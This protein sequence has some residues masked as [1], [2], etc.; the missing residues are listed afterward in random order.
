MLDTRRPLAKTIRREPDG[1]ADI[2]AATGSVGQNAIETPMGGAE[3]LG[4]RFEVTHAEGSGSGV[5]PYAMNGTP[6]N[7]HTL[8][9]PMKTLPIS[10][11]T[12]LSSESPSPAVPVF[13]GRRAIETS[14]APPV[15]NAC[16]ARL[17]RGTCRSARRARRRCERYIAGRGRYRRDRH[18]RKHRTNPFVSMSRIAEHQP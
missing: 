11:S 9:A 4:S 12:N 10:P 16:E 15:M 17:S 7:T 3:W 8:P 6:T 13:G 14:T 2:A 18:G 5:A 1:R